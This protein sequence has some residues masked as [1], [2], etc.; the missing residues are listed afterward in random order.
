MGSN[1][2]ERPFAPVCHNG[3]TI[4]L[5]FMVCLCYGADLG[6]RGRSQ[7]KGEIL[8]SEHMAWIMASDVSAALFDSLHE[9]ARGENRQ[10]AKAWDSLVNAKKKRWAFQKKVAAAAAAAEKAGNLDAPMTAT[11]VGMTERAAQSQNNN[12]RHVKQLRVLLELLEYS[13]GGSCPFCG[14][15]RSGHMDPCLLSDL[16]WILRSRDSRYTHEE[17]QDVFVEKGLDEWMRE[18]IDLGQISAGGAESLLKQVFTRRW[19]RTQ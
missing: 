18:K 11:E 16:L 10:A 12:I 17:K 9:R 1:G 3:I 8:M 15:F 2:F 5:A 4:C 19:G 14:K 6:N 7:P 13:D